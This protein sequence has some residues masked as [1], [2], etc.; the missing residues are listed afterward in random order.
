LNDDFAK[1]FGA[2]ENLQELRTKVRDDLMAKAVVNAEN[3]VRE[4]VVDQVVRSHSFDIPDSLIREEL[5][6]HVRRIAAT[7]ARQGIDVNRASID[8]SKVLEEERPH[9]EQAVR[10]GLVLDAVAR[11]ENLQVT[12]DELEN[13]F[14][15]LAEATRKSPAAIR[16][17][18]E[19]DKR[20]QGF[21]EHLLRKKALDFIFRNANITQR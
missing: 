11:L 16:A 10:R 1:D 13:E 20:I 8:W 14:Q 4:A 9:A 15:A 18:F 7:L 17:Q 6:D 21:K 2:A 3:K 12:E 19:K 5:E